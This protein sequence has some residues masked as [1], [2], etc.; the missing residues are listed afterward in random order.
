MKCY[1][2]CLVHN[3]YV[4]DMTGETMLVAGVQHKCCIDASAEGGLDCSEY[5]KNTGKPL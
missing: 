1:L 3:G 2:R 4:L 5:F